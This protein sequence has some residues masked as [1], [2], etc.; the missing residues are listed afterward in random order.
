MTARTHTCTQHVPGSR[1][2]LREGDGGVYRPD[3][4]PTTATPATGWIL[5][6]SVGVL[7]G[8]AAAACVVEAVK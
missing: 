1:T 2:E 4:S 5:L 7:A 3:P 6:A 8:G